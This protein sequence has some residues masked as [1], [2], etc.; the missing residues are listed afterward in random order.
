MLINYKITIA[1]IPYNKG[2]SGLSIF[3]TARESLPGSCLHMHS[4]KNS[5]SHCSGSTSR[6][7]MS[8][9]GCTNYHY[10]SH[11]L[12]FLGLHGQSSADTLS[13]LLCSGCVCLFM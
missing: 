2:S 4:R 1:F 12:T 10:S 5:F 6:Q 8:R 7:G 13:F 9:A 11:H 3:L